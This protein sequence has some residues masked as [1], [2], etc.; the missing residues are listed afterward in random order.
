M[1]TL[2]TPYFPV[3]MFVLYFYGRCCFV[4]QKKNNKR[5]SLYSWMLRSGCVLAV[6]NLVRFNSVVSDFTE[7]LS[8]LYV[9]GAFLAFTEKDRRELLKSFVG[10]QDY[11]VVIVGFIGLLSIGVYFQ[12]NAI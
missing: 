3:V 10:R 12:I 4:Y 11:I 1:T 6:L 8:H 9:L 7:L 5:D 2:V